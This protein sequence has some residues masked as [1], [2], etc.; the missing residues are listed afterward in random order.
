MGSLCGNGTKFKVKINRGH[1]QVE[2]NTFVK[3]HY[4]MPKDKWSCDAETVK[5]FKV[6]IWPLTFWPKI[7]RGP[8]RVKVN[9]YVKYHHCMSNGR[10]VIV[11]TTSFSQTDRQ[12]DRQSDR[13]GETSI[14]PSTSLA[15][16]YKLI[17]NVE[18]S[19]KNDPPWKS[20]IHGGSHFFTTCGSKFNVKIWTVSA[21]NVEKWPG[22]SLLTLKNDPRSHFSTGSLFNVTPAKKI[23]L[24]R[25]CP[26]KIFWPGPKPKPPPWISNGPCLTHLQ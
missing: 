4:C 8:H 10:G 25:F 22:E 1:S 14:P 7:N 20:K 21:F 18:K 6:Q 3:Y 17:F 23:I 5:K 12:M 16:V 11:Q 26:K 9:I 24:L 2:V 19:L 15:G 13:Y